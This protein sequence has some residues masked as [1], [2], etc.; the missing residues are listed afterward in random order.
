MPIT[1]SALRALVCVNFELGPGRKALSFLHADPHFQCHDDHLAGVRVAGYILI[2]LVT[3]GFPVSLLAYVHKHKRTPD[4]QAHRAEEAQPMHPNEP[5][6][7]RAAAGCGC[8]FPVQ[9]SMALH[10]STPWIGSKA[11][12]VRLTLNFMRSVY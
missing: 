5:S 8:G 12:L 6:D 3:I 2:C 11:K 1:L 9:P 4:V 10:R 7:D